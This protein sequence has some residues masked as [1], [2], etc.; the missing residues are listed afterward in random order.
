MTVVPK[1]SCPEDVKPILEKK[2][3]S[4]HSEGGN[5][6]NKDS[7]YNFFNFLCFFFLSLF[8]LQNYQPAQ[9]NSLGIEYKRFYFRF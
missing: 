9:N 4:S 7:E 3:V 8:H 6:G 1:S 2:S 5:S